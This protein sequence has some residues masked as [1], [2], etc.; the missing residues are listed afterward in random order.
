ML[1]YLEKGNWVFDMKISSKTVLYTM[2]IVGSVIIIAAIGLIGYLAWIT[3]H[4]GIDGF[5]ISG[6]GVG[7]ISLAVAVAMIYFSFRILFEEDIEG[8]RESVEKKEK[9]HIHFKKCG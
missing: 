6:F 9:K 2:R 4:V 3:S 8:K 1:L 7:V 5:L